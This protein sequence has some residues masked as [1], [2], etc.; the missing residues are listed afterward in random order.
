MQ[1]NPAELE[2][3][4]TVAFIGVLLL[5][6]YPVFLLIFKLLRLVRKV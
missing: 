6:G 4:Q 2:V 3:V 5:S 1:I